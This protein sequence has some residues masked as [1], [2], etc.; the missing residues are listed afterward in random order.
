[1][2][3][4]WLS[5]IRSS[6]LVFSL[7]LAISSYLLI[8]SI[9]PLK[10]LDDK[11][12]SSPVDN[13][14]SKPLRRPNMPHWSFAPQTTRK[15]HV[16]GFPTRDQGLIWDWSYSEIFKKTSHLWTDWL[17]S[18]QGSW[19][20]QTN[21]FLGMSMSQK[22]DEWENDSLSGARDMRAHNRFEFPATS[23]LLVNLVIQ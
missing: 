22:C 9:I 21:S 7:L 23:I 6:I 19:R 14:F 15:E 13:S 16:I 8:M 12:L 5:G 1:M 3:I 4:L 18:P 11:R 2:T 20:E 17:S 10:I